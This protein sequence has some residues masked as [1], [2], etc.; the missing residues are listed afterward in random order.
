MERIVIANFIVFVIVYG[1]CTIIGLD[2]KKW[3]SWLAGLYGFLSGCFF[4]FTREDGSPSLLMGM[5]F[6]VVIMSSGAMVRRNRQRYS[7]EAAEE[8]LA[9]YGQEKHHSLLARMIEKLLG[10]R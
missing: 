8:W 7:R 3:Y 5:L 2:L 4:G 10:K 1:I 6:A 9:R